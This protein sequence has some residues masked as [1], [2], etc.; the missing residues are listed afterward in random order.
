ML[1]CITLISCSSSDMWSGWVYPNK[2]S[3]S[4]YRS[5]GKSFSSLESCRNEA[6]RIIRANKWSN[7]DYECGLNCKYDEEIGVNVC[8]ETSR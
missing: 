3:L 4:N 8:K 1:T 2:D 5:I 7:A 6:M